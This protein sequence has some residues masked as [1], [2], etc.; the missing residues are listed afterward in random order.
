MGGS[1]QADCSRLVLTNIDPRMLGLIRTL[2]ARRIVNVNVNI[3]LAGLLALAPTLVVVHIAHLL[4]VHNEWA[5]NAVTL[6]SDIIFDVL[7]YYVLHWLANHWPKR[8]RKPGEH[9]D[10]PHLSYFKDATLVQIQRMV[11]SPVL[12]ALFLGTQHI[13]LKQ[14]ADPVWA[15]TIG[16]CVGMCFSRTAH[17]FWML[18]EARRR[19]EAAAIRAA[20]DAEAASPPAG[21]ITE[22]T[23]P[24]RLPDPG[25]SV[26]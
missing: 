13:L 23:G 12:Y 26:A 4:G 7:I 21:M 9:P 17:T 2:Y 11:L 5:I 19:R 15:T 1:V 18:R 3:V 8:W 20:Q 16:F 6:V 10:T 22:S 24:H 25:E 14:G